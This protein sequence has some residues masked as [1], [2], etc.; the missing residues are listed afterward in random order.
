MNTAQHVYDTLYSHYGPQHWWPVTY[1]KNIFPTYAG[2]PINHKQQLEVIFGAILTQNTAWTNVEKAI[3]NL[4]KYNLINPNKISKIRPQKLAALI[5][6]V[7]YFNQKAQ[8]LK[9][10]SNYLLKQY[11]GNLKRMFKKELKEL[12]KELLSIK[13]IGPET[14]DSILLYAAKK[15]SFVVDAYTKRIFYRL[16]IIHNGMMDYNQLQSYFHK[17]F[18]GAEKQR[19]KL[20]NEYHAL[21]VEHGKK[22]CRK[23]PLCSSCVLEKACKKRL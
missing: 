22:V 13:G 7:G 10:F 23:E 19:T 15:P 2:G 20:F 11:D 16:G 8:K 3:I 14:A 5:R 17:N 4:N 12:R 1:E 18:R 21:M 6:P 9:I